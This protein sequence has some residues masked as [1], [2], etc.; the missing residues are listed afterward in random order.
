MS[1]SGN[2]QKTGFWDFNPQTDLL[3]P[4]GEQQH[5]RPEFEASLDAH[6]K[7][8]TFRFVLRLSPRNHE[9]L[10]SLSNGV[11]S[12]ADINPDTL[13][14]YSTFIHETIHWWQHVGSTSGLLLSLSYLGQTHS[15][16][17]ELRNIIATF[18]PTKPLK[19]WTDETLLREGITAQEKLSEANIAVNNALDIEFYKLIALNPQRNA[20]ILASQQ[21]FESIGHSYHIA[22]GQLLGMLSAITDKDFL[23][24]PNAKAWEAEFRKLNTTKHEGFYH[25]SPIKISPV[26]LH[27]IYEG[28]ARFI[29]LQFLNNTYKNSPTCENWKEL[30]FLSGIYVEAF[31]WFLKISNSDWPT[32]ISDPIVAL[33]LL[34]CDLSINPTRGFPFD[35]SNFEDFISDIDVGI[36]FFRLSL[37]VAKH[38]H[39]KSAIKLHNRDEYISISETL[40]STTGY[41]HPLSALNKISKWITESPEIENLM[42]EH[43]TFEFKQT[44]QSIRVFFSHFLSFSQDKLEHPEFFCWPAKWMASKNANS[45]DINEIWMRHLSLFTDRGDMPGVYPRIFS[46]RD[47]NAIQAVFENFY[48]TMSIYDLTSQWI[49]SEG[50]FKCD[51]RWLF[52]NYSQADAEAWADNNF[53]AIYGVSFKDFDILEN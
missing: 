53:K 37:A 49:L 18:G 45:I 10:N 32:N 43:K 20:K 31:E 19:R 40:T 12:A 36:R 41:D 52:K 27:A 24:L 17:S 47:K 35:I 38:P 26:G 16:M 5:A 6:G 23:L 42:L 29:Q 39:L 9:L 13:Q 50:P 22:Y 48:A 33:F 34:V 15:S 3:N 51:Y 28:Q 2:I 25:G 30:G 14:A 46:G 8:E 7:Y 21:H 4:L 44:N 1:T 11:H